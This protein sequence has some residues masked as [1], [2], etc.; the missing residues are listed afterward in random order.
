[1]EVPQ[2]KN[3]L[4]K[5]LWLQEVYNFKEMVENLS[6]IK[7]T[8]DKLDNKIKLVNRKR[9]AMQRINDYRRLPNPPISGLDACSLLRFRSIR[10]FINSLKTQ[11][12]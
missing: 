2:R 8:K 4:D 5:Q 11:K 10:T 9:K 7:I 12:I 6:G 3:P 1:M